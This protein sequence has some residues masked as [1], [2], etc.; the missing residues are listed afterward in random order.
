MSLG[1]VDSFH[2]AHVTYRGDPISVRDYI[3]VAGH[4]RHTVRVNDH[5]RKQPVGGGTDLMRSA[6]VDL[7][8]VATATDVDPKTDSAEREVEDSLALA[9]GEE[10]RL[11]VLPTH[12]RKEPC[13]GR[14]EVLRLINDHMRIWQRPTLFGHPFSQ[15]RI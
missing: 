2:L 1:L 8:A 9:A 13:L 12:S 15:T 7:Q 14:R 6:V 10:D 11:L 5:T 3:V 4:H